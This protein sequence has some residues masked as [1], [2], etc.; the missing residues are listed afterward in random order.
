MSNNNDPCGDWSLK[1]EYHRY[2]QTQIWAGKREQALERTSHTC[3]LC[4]F[5][6]SEHGYTPIILNVHHLTYDRL[7]YEEP[8]DLQ[9]LCRPCHKKQHGIQ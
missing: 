9:V 3:E 2:L 8:K 1:D 6:A 7:G 4:G 5:V